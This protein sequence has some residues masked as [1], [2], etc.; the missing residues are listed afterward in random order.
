MNER[1]AFP[2][3]ELVG[4]KCKDINCEGV[5]VH[6]LNKFTKNCYLKCSICNNKFDFNYNENND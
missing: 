1:V 5:L 2:L 4:P 3:F 6:T